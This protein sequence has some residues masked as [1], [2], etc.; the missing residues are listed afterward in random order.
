MFES[1]EIE[2]SVPEVAIALVGL[3]GIVFAHAGAGRFADR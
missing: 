3:T 1:G 2:R